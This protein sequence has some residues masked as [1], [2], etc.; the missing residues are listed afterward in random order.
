MAVTVRVPTGQLRRLM[1]ARGATTQSELIND[2]RSEAEEQLEADAVLCAR[3]ARAV[4][5]P[6]SRAKGRGES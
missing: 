5:A 3:L 4:E 6:R 2:L 1:R